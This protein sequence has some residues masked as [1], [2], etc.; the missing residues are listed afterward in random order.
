MING[1]GNKQTLSAMQR[2]LLFRLNVSELD[3]RYEKIIYSYNNLC[4]HTL[5]EASLSHLHAPSLPSPSMSIYIM[6]SNQ[7]SEC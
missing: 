1:S 4:G 7:H 6:V 2:F 3:I 5:N